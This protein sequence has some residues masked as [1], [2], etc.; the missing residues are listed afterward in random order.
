MARGTLKKIWREHSLSIAL[1]LGFVACTGMSLL[2]EPGTRWYDF[3]V[4]LS[5][6]FSG[7]F[8]IV[9]LAIKLWERGSD[10]A[11]PPEAK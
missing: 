2:H 6:A 7:G 1:G 11:K 9:L 10:P 8:V 5:G 3:W 4:S